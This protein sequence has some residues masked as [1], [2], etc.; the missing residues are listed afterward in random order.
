MGQTLLLVLNMS[1][2][3]SVMIV[4]VLLLRLLLKKAPRSISYALWAVVLFRL[5][6]PV[7]FSSPISLLGVLPGPAPEQG[8]MEYISV[9]PGMGLPSQ[10]EA[11]PLEG[12]GKAQ[13]IPSIPVSGEVRLTAKLGKFMES[14]LPVGAVIWLLGAGAMILYGGLSLV[15]LNRRLRGARKESHEIYLTH[16]VSTPFVL[17]FFRYRIYLPQGI[18]QQEREY[19]LLHERTHI[20]RGDPLTRGLAYLALCLHWFNPLV[21][22]AFFVSGQDMEVCCDEAVIRKIGNQVKKEY[23][24]SLLAVAAGS[25]P[26]GRIP[27]AFGEGNPR[28]RILH[29]LNY[30]KPASVVVVLAAAAGILAAVLLLANPGKKPEP[31][32]YW[33]VVTELTMEEEATS[34]L[35]VTIPGTGEVVIPQA[36]EVYPYIE[37]D[38]DGL[39]EGNLIRITFPGG[40]EPGIM[41]TYPAQFSAE[42]ESIA[43][44]G[45]GFDIESAGAGRWR[46]GVPRGMAP[47]AQEGQML[48]IYHH[49]PQIDGQ[50]TELLT[51]APVLSV[52]EYRIWVELSAEEAVVFFKE[53]GFGIA[54]RVAEQE[55]DTG[56]D[57]SGAEEAETV[58]QIGKLDREQLL[59]PGIADGPYQV[60]VRS[61]SRSARG[62][63]RYVVEDW[64]EGEELPFLAFGE[65]CTFLVNQEMDRI[66]Y[67]QTPYDQFVKLTEDGLAYQN[68]PLTLTFQGG[69]IV[70]AVLDSAFYERGISY[71]P[72]PADTWYEFILEEAGSQALEDFYTLVETR[73]QDV[74]DSQGEEELA[75]Y[76][77]NIGDGDS[78]VVLIRDASGQV[79]YSLSAH[80]SRAGW[81]NIYVGELEGT[82]YLLTLH[83]EDRGD[84]GAYAYHVFR[85]SNTGEVRQIAG[86][87]FTF[88]K[89]RIPY[90]DSRFFTWAEG[91]GVYLENSRL[92][93]STQ[94]GELRT[95][96]V[97]DTDR[98]NY[99]T[100]R[101]E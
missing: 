21:W 3:A 4:A 77:G 53:F 96:W 78:G 31:I 28:G 5:L 40:E 33:G 59:A 25:G 69:V 41:E 73:Q 14:F 22:A 56:E 1:L 23:S 64:Q 15:H 94:E 24:A 92:L 19:I 44:M 58:M 57:T 12:D 81:N 16:A 83:I 34:R 10:K 62:I 67:D 37:M 75:V 30:K 66:L 61:L 101:R 46:I 13:D 39:E 48:A 97:S 9:D 60:Y 42:A 70:E 98:Y 47:E 72:V 54:C 43:V 17:G 52:E 26:A 80:V 89:D 95:Q 27:L 18:R 38:F 93:L 84:Y 85:L 82:G 90:D 32:R 71:S 87:S 51:T 68:V 86:S 65:D 63:D 35:V 100:L 49:D 36:E 55:E 99:N 7:S 8:R 20:R 91:M 45:L 6:C 50:K 11:L 88:D 76:T 2:T 79:L 29:V 74:A